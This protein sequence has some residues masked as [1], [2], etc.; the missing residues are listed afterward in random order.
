[1]AGVGRRIADTLLA[2][3]IP[4]VVAE[5]NREIVEKLRDA[6]MPAV[7]GN[8]GEPGVLIQAH[9]A[10][11]RMLVIATPETIEVRRMLTTAR[12]LNPQIEAVLRTHNEEEAARLERENA[13]KV[14]RG[15][16]ELAKSMANYVLERLDADDART[17]TAQ[18]QSA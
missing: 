7:S 3:G 6:G 4:F 18:E 2:R 11:A 14:F 17:R 5:A 8:A 1:M 15:E 10:E 16:N 13:G 9:I 12:T